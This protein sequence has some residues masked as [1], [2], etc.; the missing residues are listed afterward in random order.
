MTSNSH[1]DF[2]LCENHLELAPRLSSLQKLNYSISN[3]KVNMAGRGAGSPRRGAFRCT[4]CQRDFMARKTAFRHYR[5][6]HPAQAE[7]LSRHESW[8][9]AADAAGAGQGSAASA[10]LSSMSGGPNDGNAAASAADDDNNNNNNNNTTA[11]A[12][13]S[14][15]TTTNNNN[16]HTAAA[17]TPTD[18]NDDNDGDYDMDT[19]DNNNEVADDAAFFLLTS[20]LTP[21][22]DSPAP[23]LPSPDPQSTSQNSFL[24]GSQLRSSRSTR[25]QDHNA[26]ARNRA[27]GLDLDPTD[28]LPVQKF[29]LRTVRVSQEGSSDQ[30]DGAN[31]PG[32]QS[33]SDIWR[34]PPLPSFFNQLP[35]HSQALLRR[36]RMGNTNVT[37]SEW[38]RKTNSWIPGSEVEA[39]NAR[40]KS[41]H[42]LTVPDSPN[43]HD[44]DDN[45]EDNDD[46]LDADGLPPKRRRQTAGLQERYLE[47][48]KWVPIDPARAEKLPEPK[49]LADRR[50]GM[51]S[52][53]GGAYKATNG[54]GTLGANPL[55]SSDTVSYDLGEG[56]GLGNASGVLGSTSNAPPAPTP[57]RRNMPP[58]RK[59]KKLGGPGRRKA[60]PTPLGENAPATVPQDATMT[61]TGTGTSVGDST[62]AATQDGQAETNPDGDAEG[63]GSES[64]GEGSEEG[65][66]EEN[67]PA[68]TQTQTKLDDA[69]TRPPVG[70]SAD[71]Q[72]Q[73]QPQTAT[74]ASEQAQSEVTA[75]TTQETEANQ[76]IPAESL[77]DVSSSTSTA[78]QQAAQVDEA[79]SDSAPQTQT[80]PEPTSEIPD[81]DM[82][83]ALQNLPSTSALPEQ[84]DSA[85]AT[86]NDTAATPAD[87][88]P[89][90]EPELVL[91]QLDRPSIISSDP[92]IPQATAVTNTS[93]TEPEPTSETVTTEDA[94]APHFEQPQEEEQTTA[95]EQK[96]EHKQDQ[97]G[98]E[99]LSQA[100]DPVKVAETTNVDGM[101]TA[102]AHAAAGNDITTQ[103]P[104]QGETLGETRAQ[105]QTHIQPEQGETL[106]ETRAQ[107]QTH[108]QP[109]QGE[110]LGETQTQTQ[111]PQLQSSGE[112]QG[113][114]HAQAQAHQQNGGEVDLLGGLEAAVEKEHRAL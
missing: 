4:V 87:V 58:K 89:E 20:H 9:V 63:P 98:E 48:K 41:K 43:S 100:Q 67:T 79:V 70:S 84:Q 57:V 92:T 7:G 39:R 81:T 49:Y 56:A 14:I 91:E 85:T 31:Q 83:M 64:E 105:I 111:P 15:S 71:S 40:L 62:P 108:I 21:P 73:P 8:V 32:Q 24:T 55:A 53:Y 112:Q 97:Q 66:I 34:E 6:Q 54:F 35:Q 61:G 113:E 99:P 27:G 19:E 38:D 17:P 13:T 75:P 29:E 2:V 22:S 1:L 78:R 109:E 59:K 36:A 10:A 94:V 33:G 69:A 45:G 82:D 86:T 25:N 46:L 74:A 26:A 37:P 114:E 12:A 101:M 76:T 52:L 28:G 47:V 103:Q 42:L 44:E 23:G 18:T 50:P 102:S 65:E 106:G 77:H 107:I 16:T 90:A 3:G 96:Q 93:T 51:Q 60:N 68:Q 95:H 11:A 5:D 80:Q 30:N 104:E 72:S 88:E 110:T